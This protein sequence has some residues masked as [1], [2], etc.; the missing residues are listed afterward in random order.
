VGSAEP[1][2]AFEA[3]LVGRTLGDFVLRRQLGA[4]GFGAVFLAEQQALGR[5]AVVKVPLRKREPVGGVHRAV[6]A[7]GPL[8]SRLDHPYAAHIYAF[9]SEPDGT[10]VDRD[11]AR[12]RHHRSTSC[13]PGAGPCRRSGWPRCSRRSARSST[14]RA[15]AGHRPPR[16]QAGQRHGARPAPASS[17]PSCS[18]SASP[19]SATAAGPPRPGEPDTGADA[20]ADPWAGPRARGGR[21]DHRRPGRRASA[22]RRT[23]RPS[24][25]ATRPRSTHRAD[26]Y[27]LGVLAYRC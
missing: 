2:S 7:R 15:R 11:G 10:A 6:P 22:R 3:K 1:R 12:A 23:W 4:G 17:C 27:A 24:S 21:P 14:R 18:T 26:I 20:A 19:S 8:A 25:G 9:G 13:W 16:H 5:E